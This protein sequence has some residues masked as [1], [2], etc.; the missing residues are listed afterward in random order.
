MSDQAQV[1]SGVSSTS[2]SEDPIF[3]AVHNAFQLGW[4]II[5]LKSRIQIAALST[6]ITG[7]PRAGS[8]TGSTNSSQGQASQLLQNVISTV[9]AAKTKLLLPESQQN[10]TELPDNAWLTSLWR[11]TFNRIVESHKS[12]FP[13]SNTTGTLYNL[14]PHSN[15]LSYAALVANPQAYD[16]STMYLPYL[17]LYPDN[18][19]DYA[20]VGIQHQQHDKLT[21]YTLYDVTRRAINCLTL[22]YIDPNES[23]ISNTVSDFQRQLVQNVTNFLKLAATINNTT[24]SGQSQGDPTAL[25]QPTTPGGDK[26]PPG[27]PGTDTAD[28]SCT[29]FRSAKNQYNPTLEHSIRPLPGNMGYLCTRNPLCERR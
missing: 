8:T 9:S 13:A 21:E 14:P 23:L 3:S 19:L 12:C 20:D 10:L 7:S 26:V 22:L 27:Q 4:S 28:P 5:E 16:A 15:T 6:S 18:E 24:Q 29:P 17:Y 1:D 25:N 11:A 2:L